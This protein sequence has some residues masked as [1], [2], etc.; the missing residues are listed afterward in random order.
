[1]GT[2]RQWWLLFAVPTSL[3]GVAG[4][5]ALARPE[6]PTPS[7]AV[8][9]L[10]L[11][12]GSVVLGLAVLGWWGRT[13]SRPPTHGAGLWR[14]LT[15][16]AGSWMA[17]E[18]VLFAMTAA[19]ADVLPLSGLTVGRFGAYVTDISAGRIDLAV[20]ACTAA[21][22]GWSLFAFRH[23]G[24]RLPVAVAVPAT[25]ALV[26]RPVTGHMSQQVLGS[27][28]DAVHALAA[29][30]WFGLLAALALTLRSRG[31]WSTWLPRYSN[32][33]VWCVCLLT[34]TGVVDAAVRLGGPDALLDT[35]YGRVVIAKAV[36]LA[37]LLALGWWW[38]RTWVSRAAAHRMSADDSL[39]RAALEVVAMAIAFGLAAALAT[40]A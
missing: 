4:G 36:V 26:A 31:D 40:T 1:M 13:G 12:L 8:R 6:D 38:R 34:V 7:S 18:A 28:L 24:A 22:T 27:A 17:A 37:A 3:V 21:A 20:F 33:A 29:A 16:L 23:P 35:G 10:C 5:W 39:Q 30:T 11:I 14:L 19:E 2:A 15:A 25:F 9:A 32:V